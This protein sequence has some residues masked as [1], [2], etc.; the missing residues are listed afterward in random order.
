MIWGSSWPFSLKETN[1][2]K[3]LTSAWDQFLSFR[4]YP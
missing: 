4:K 1:S 3:L 2:P